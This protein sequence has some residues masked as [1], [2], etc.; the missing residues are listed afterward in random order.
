VANPTH[1]LNQLS[2]DMFFEHIAVKDGRG[3]FLVM[4]GLK[5]LGV[6]A[7]RSLQAVPRGE[8]ERNRIGDL[9][10]PHEELM[11]VPP[12]EDLNRVV[13]EMSSAAVNQVSAV[14]EDKVVGI[15]TWSS[16]F[17]AVGRSVE[18][19]ELGGS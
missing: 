1:V 3:C 13:E 17:A 19:P 18:K 8:W 12:G 15:V 2:L 11:A 7:T 5:P 9:M 14:E 4:E 16:I 10:T 6:V